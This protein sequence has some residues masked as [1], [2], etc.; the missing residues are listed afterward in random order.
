M[1]TKLHES[2][3]HLHV[4]APTRRA[5]LRAASVSMASLPGW[6]VLEVQAATK[7]FDEAR[8]RKSRDWFTDTPLIDQ[9]GRVHRFYSD[10]LAPPGT[11]RV[12]V[13][14]PLYTSCSSAC[15]LIVQ[16]LLHTRAALDAA[17]QRELAILSISVDPLTDT[18]E[19]LKGFATKHGADVLGWHFLG[20][21]PHDV[22]RVARRL[23]LWADAPEDHA[24][25]LIAGRAAGA[26]WA[27]LRPDLDPKAL[28]Q[29]LDRFW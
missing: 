12:V 26:H 7:T 11:P 2:A 19:V 9:N 10:L 18:P 13:V 15:P 6:S 17:R 1:K 21:K 16:R 8:E 29:Q 25:V 28:A 24:T 20:G 4:N 14:H 5:V 22:E 23:G 3:T 27:K